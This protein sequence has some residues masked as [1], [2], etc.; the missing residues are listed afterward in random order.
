MLLDAGR[1]YE[2]VLL[3]GPGVEAGRRRGQ[4]HHIL[5][6]SLVHHIL[7]LTRGGGSWH[8]HAPKCVTTTSLVGARVLLILSRILLCLLDQ[9]RDRK[10]LL[11][12][13]MSFSP[14]GDTWDVSTLLREFQSPRLV[15]IRA[16]HG[17][18]GFLSTYGIAR[19]KELCLTSP[20][21]QIYLI[22]ISSVHHAPSHCHRIISVVPH[23][24][25]LRL[26]GHSIELC[27]LLLMLLA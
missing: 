7:L 13:V 15:F 9:L 2:F 4:D 26:I 6:L 3:W 22:I 10:V 8:H 20:H 14:G 24:A 21:D 1:R 12:L 18:T 16:S 23:Y 19:D 11:L 5:R 25:K 17:I 27:L